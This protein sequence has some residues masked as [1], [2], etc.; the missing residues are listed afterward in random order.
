MPLDSSVKPQP[1][2]GR[3]GLS[4]E[5]Y[6]Q[7]YQALTAPDGAPPSQRQLRKYLGTGNNNTLAKY[8]RRIA[9]ERVTD[10]KPLETGS[11][12]AELLATVQRLATQI[13]L[14]E[15]QVADDRVNEIRKESE[16]RVRIAEAT[17]EKRLQDT[18]LLEHRATTAESE[19]IKLRESMDKVELESNDL[20]ATLQKKIQALKE[21]NAALVQS[22]ADAA[23]TIATHV[24]EL[25]RRQLIIE[26]AATDQKA[27]EKTSQKQQTALQSELAESKQANATLREKYASLNT[28]FEDQVAQ[29]NKQNKHYEDLQSRF[30]QA[31]QKIEKTSLHLDDATLANGA[32]ELQVAEISGMLNAE[33][34]I[35]QTV[36]ENSDRALAD[37]TLLI[38]ELRS[39]LGKITENK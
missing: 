38:D 36:V 24:Q 11:L 28:R 2:P 9:E 35:H 21:Q 34:R 27:A 12:D 30:E 37:K 31:A 16:Q 26:K 1:G 8:R 14:D 23:D 33:K 20:N 13:A 18:A 19:L 39:A 6:E 15:S 29:I 3:P 17:M 25:A 32:L 22:K 7:A 10:G 5:A 4:F